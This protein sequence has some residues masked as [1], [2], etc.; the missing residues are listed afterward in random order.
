MTQDELVRVVDRARTGL[1]LPALSKSDLAVIRA[2]IG[3]AEL[4][5]GQVGPVEGANRLWSDRERFVDPFGVLPEL[6]ELV[7]AWETSIGERPSTEED[8]RFVRGGSSGEGRDPEW[9]T[10]RADD[11][12][13]LLEQTFARFGIR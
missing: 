7:D 13:R 6:I 9:D 12:G 4:A 1:S 10:P 3:L 2:H 8:I 11:S 5:E